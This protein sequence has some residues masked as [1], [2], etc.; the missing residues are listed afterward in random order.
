MSVLQVKSTA[1]F[2]VQCPLGTSHVL[3]TFNGANEIKR[4]YFK[5]VLPVQL[6]AGPKGSGIQKYEN[7]P[8]LF[9]FMGAEW[10]QRKTSFA[11]VMLS[12]NPK[13]QLFCEIV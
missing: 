8:G 5:N 2:S 10:V 6:P 11:D 7:T 1:R 13:T 12:V 4:Q 3:L 9:E